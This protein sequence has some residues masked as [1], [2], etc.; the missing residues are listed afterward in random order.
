M[1]SQRAAFTHGVIDGRTAQEFEPEGKAAEEIGDGSERRLRS[2]TKRPSLFAVKPTIAPAIVNDPQPEASADI[3][4][5]AKRRS[6]PRAEKASV[7]CRSIY[8]LRPGNSFE[9]CPSIS[10]ARHRP[11]ARK[12]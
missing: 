6:G 9:C 4:V 2:M 7:F 11:S 8:R 5:A 3:A 1:L 10:A 12:P